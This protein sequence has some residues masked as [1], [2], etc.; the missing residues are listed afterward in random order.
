MYPQLTAIAQLGPRE[1]V[2]TLITPHFDAYCGLRF[3]ALCREALPLLYQREGI[4]GPFEVGEY[5]DAKTQIEVVGYRK[6]EGIDIGECKWGSVRRAGPMI[7]ALAAKMARY[8]T[9]HHLTIRGRIF[10]RLRIPTD[11][12][13]ARW[14]IHILEELYALG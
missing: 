9:P 12:V 4:H 3:E 6:Q 14:R 5:W 10:S 11:R 8:P 7:A 13:D 1:A 2:R